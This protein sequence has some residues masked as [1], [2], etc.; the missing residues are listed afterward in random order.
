MRILSQPSLLIGLAAICGTI[1]FATPAFVDAPLRPAGLAQV[2]AVEVLPEGD[3][4]LLD[5]GFDAGL[6][7]GIIC[8]IW[9]DGVVIADVVMVAARSDR[10]VALITD[11]A[12]GVRISRD[13]TALIKT[14]QF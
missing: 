12:A 14:L 11:L 1:A 2:A 13:D 8:E 9:R 6:R 10:S 5:S 7:P 4:V 3:L